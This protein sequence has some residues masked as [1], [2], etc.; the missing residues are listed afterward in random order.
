MSRTPLPT[1]IAGLSSDEYAPVPPNPAELKARTAVTEKPV[2]SDLLAGRTSTATVLRTLDRAAGGG[3]FAIPADAE[4]S[5]DAAEDAFNRGP[6]SYVIDVQTH[7]VNPDRW[8]GG[9]AE[10]LAGFLC[11]VDPDR[12][13]GG[14][15]PEKLSA[16]KW[17]AHLFGQSETNIALLTSLPGRVH[18]NVLTN[19]EIASC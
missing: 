15:D 17:A 13:A 18:E 1:L 4:V 8:R 6:G 19:R 9:S 2:R 14:I 3:F 12:W 7:L 10:A 16:A 11:M 5:D